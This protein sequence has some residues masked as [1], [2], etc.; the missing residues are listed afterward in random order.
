MALPITGQAQ[1]L[2]QAIAQKSGQ[3]AALSTGWNNELIV[4]ELLPKYA[5][6]VLAG[7]VFGAAQFLG[8]T[9]PAG[10]SASPTT[11]TLYNPAGSGKNALILFTSITFLVA[12]AAGAIVALAVSPA[13]QQAAVTG[14]A[15]VP[16]NLLVGSGNVSGIK[17]FTTATLAAAP[18]S[19]NV[20]AIMG[21]GLTGAITVATEA[22]VMEREFAG[23]LI[24]APGTAISY[25]TSTAG[26]AAGAAAEFIWAELPA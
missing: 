26:G 24:L 1:G 20:V 6:L 15:V 18:V 19:G 12:F 11:L 2:I 17:A 23:A 5:A 3:P 21:A 10:L 22:Q 16:Q 13:T 4:S 9:T 8:T 7:T 25:Q 14:T